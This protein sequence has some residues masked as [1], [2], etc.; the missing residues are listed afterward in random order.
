ME[1]KMRFEDNNDNQNRADE[2]AGAG[3]L[4]EALAGESEFVVPEEK[5][6][7]LNRSTL[8]LILLVVLG[9]GGLYFMHLRTG[10]KAAAAAEAQE[11]SKTIA[12]F[13]SGGD[14]S[15][16]LMEKALRD[17]ELV[18]KR[19][20]EYPSTTQ[21][22]LNELRT[23][24]FRKSADEPADAPQTDFSAKRKKEEERLAIL[25]AVQ[26]LQLQSVMSGGSQRACMI[27]NTLV[28]EGQTIEGF[29]LEKI[30]AG[31]VIVKNGT[32]R[33]EL[34]MQQR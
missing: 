23:N 24:P 19:F 14:G 15:I 9:G 31:A 4:S 17:T 34:R 5:K 20:V 21:V 18:V 30:N 28:K 8:V 1:Q 27:N 6:P 13:L 32:Y 2:S 33:F 11:A 22:P 7:S 29:T 12:T 16:K 10:P 3:D 26:G 25:K